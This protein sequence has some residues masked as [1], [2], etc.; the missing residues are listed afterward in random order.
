MVYLSR[1]D[2]ILYY[3]AHKEYKPFQLDVRPDYK[4]S[5][6]ITPKQFPHYSKR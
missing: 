2:Y 3:F 5:T 1:P 6:S 4:A